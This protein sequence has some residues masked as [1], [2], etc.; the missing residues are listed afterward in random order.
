MHHLPKDTFRT[1]VAIQ[2]RIA[3]RQQES[4]AVSLPEYAWSE[5]QEVLRQI[6]LAQK[7]GWLVAA[8]HLSSELR[9]QLES[10]RYQLADLV[11]SLR[12]QAPDQPPPTEGEI[13]REI[14][15]L[16]AEFDDVELESK[17]GE[18]RVIVGPIVLEDIHLGRFQICLDWGDSSGS[19]PYRVVALDPN[20][21]AR[22]DSVPHPHV[23]GETLCEGEGRVAIRSALAQGRLL[24]FFTIVSQT[25]STYARGSAHVELDSWFGESCMDCRSTVYEEERYYCHRCDAVLCGSCDI[26]CQGCSNGFCSECISTCHECHADY[27]SSCLDSCPAC[28]RAT[29][30][31]CLHNGI[32]RSCHDKQGHERNEEDDPDGGAEDRPSGR[33]DAQTRFQS[34]VDEESGSAL[35]V[36]SGA[37][38]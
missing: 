20:P 24:D 18:I 36:Q 30:V 7:R 25:L 26:T 16:Q 32:C 4:F 8:R 33:P 27:C 15:A 23:Q 6:E 19:T 29:C 10:C 11:N 13:Y 31:D 35:A 22:D 17:T 21:A 1:A 3:R 38:V 14:L 9:C 28:R 12:G 2:K 34:V 37:A 5:A